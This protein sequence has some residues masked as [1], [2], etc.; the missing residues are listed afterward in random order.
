MV[1]TLAFI[2]SL[3]MKLLQL[4]QRPLRM[5]LE[6]ATTCSRIDSGGPVTAWRS[7]TFSWW[8]KLLEIM[9]RRAS[10]SCAAM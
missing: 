8:W 1:L 7:L 2:F 4:S 5:A 6:A 3:M 9:R 10:D